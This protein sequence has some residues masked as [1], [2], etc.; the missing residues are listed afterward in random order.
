MKT[1][2][3]LTN[4][5]LRRDADTHR[6]TGGVSE[7]NRSEGFVPAFRDEA[8]GK[9]YL[10]R[11]PDGVVAPIH[12]LGGL[13]DEVVTRRDCVGRIVAVRGTLCAGFV[14]CGRFYTREQ[15]AHHTHHPDSPA[16]PLRPAAL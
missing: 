1:D 2:A 11:Y 7:E 12:L 14:R 5:A 15:A 6:G 13:P 10:S 9:V 4:E 8:T 3:T 16:L